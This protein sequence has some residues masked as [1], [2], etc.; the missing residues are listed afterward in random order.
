MNLKVIGSGSAGNAYLLQQ[1]GYSLLLEAG[2]NWQEILKELPDGLRGIRACLITHEHKDHCKSVSYPVRYGI[3]TLMSGGTLL[4]IQKTDRK[5]GMMAVLPQVQIVKAGDV[6]YTNP[7]TVMAVQAAHDAVEPLAFLI[8][9][10]GTG[11]TV[12]YA[13]DTY[14]LPNKYPGINHWLV[15]CNY[16]TAKAE[17][18]LTKPKMAPLY[19]RLMRSHLSLERLVQALKTNNLE[20]TR[21]IVLIHISDERGDSDYMRETVQKATGVRTVAAVNGMN[22]QL[23]ECPF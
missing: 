14:M 20:N 6:V 11:E 13:T 8:R 22:I 19:E 15:E 17:E 5:M 21:T 3:R 1:G 18:L 9:H 16:T 23:G 7:F 4:E 10:E 2:L 12:L